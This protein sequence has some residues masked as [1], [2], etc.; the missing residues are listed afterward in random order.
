MALAAGRCRHKANT[1]LVYDV[2]FLRADELDSFGAEEISVWVQSVA[3]LIK[4]FNVS[5]V[6]A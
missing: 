6:D 2:S 5:I 3:Q 4:D 1:T